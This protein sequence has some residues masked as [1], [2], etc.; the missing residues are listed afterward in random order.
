[1]LCCSGGTA[2]QQR[3]EVTAG[4]NHASPATPDAVA[5]QQPGQKAPDRVQKYRDRLASVSA[6]DKAGRYGLFAHGKAFSASHIVELDYFEI[7]RSYARYE[8][9]PGL[10]A[11]LEGDLFVGHA[12]SSATCELYHCY[13]MF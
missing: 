12:L 3:F 4:D 1:M 10:I 7:E 13:G 5:E 2:E 11:D 8:N 9:Q 6:E